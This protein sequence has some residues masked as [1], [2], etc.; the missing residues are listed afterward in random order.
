MT[1][2]LDPVGQKLLVLPISKE[3]TKLDS[4]VLV[5]NVNNAQLG[6]GEIIAVSKPLSTMYKVGEKVLYYEK[7]GVGVIHNNKPHQLIDGGDGLMQ[8]DVVAIVSYI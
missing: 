6:E 5:A 2:I 4:G 1:T 3:E 7:R 8:G